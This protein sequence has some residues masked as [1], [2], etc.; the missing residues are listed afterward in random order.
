MKMLKTLSTLLFLQVNAT[1]LY[2]IAFGTNSFSGINASIPDGT[3]SGIQDVRIVASEIVELS[4][5]RI[6]LK[7][8]GN[9]NGDLYGY[10]RHQSGSATHISVLLNRPGRTA[11]NPN[12]YSDDGLDATFA[13]SAAADIHNYQSVSIPLPGTPL[14]GV[15]QPDGRFVDPTLVTSDSARSTLLS[16]F[17]GLSASGEWTLFLADVDPGGTNMLE[18]WGLEFIG[19]VLPTITWAAPSSIPYGTA[20]GTDQ[21][22]ATAPVPGTFS[23]SPAAGTVLHAGQGQALTVTF[24]PDDTNQY[25]TAT[26]SVAL[27]VL[28]QPL[29]ITSGSTNKTYGETMTF[30]GTEFTVTGLVNGDIVSSVTLT[31]PGTAASAPVGNHSIVPSAP[32]GINAANYNIN[33]VAGSLMVQP[34]TLAARA[35]DQS[36]PYGQTN[37]PLTIIYTGFVN[38]QNASIVTG[39]SAVTIADTNSPT[40]DYPITVS[41]QSAPNYTLS[42]MNGNLT[43]DPAPLSV[44]ANNV[45]CSYRGPNPILTA[46]ISGLMNGED[47]NVLDGALVLSTTA[48][49]ESAVGSYSIVPSGLSSTNYAIKFINGTLTVRPHELVI[50]AD[51]AGRIYGALNPAFTG[52]I[53][54]LQDGDNIT[55]TFTTSATTSSPVGAYAIVPTLSDPDGRLANYSITLTN[56]QL[57]IDPAPLSAML[58][59]P[60][61]FYGQTNPVFPI[62]YEGFVNGQDA[63][64]ITGPEGGT[65]TAQ[66]NSPIGTYPVTLAGQTAPNYSITPVN[67]ILTIVPAPLLVSADDARRALG[68]PNPIFTATI[69]GLMN[70]EDTNVLDGALVLSTTADEESAVG[71]YSIVPSGLSSTNYAIEFTNGTL[72]VTPYELVVTADSASRTYGALN[73]PFTGNIVGLQDGDNITASY[74]TPAT[75]SSPVGAYAIVPTLNDP[76]GKLTNYSVTLSHGQ[77]TVGPAP[78]LVSADDASRQFG[79]TNP[80]FTATISGLV[81]SDGINVL[82]GTLALTTFADVES[83]I[84]TY[85]IV[86]SGLTATNYAIQFTNGTLT[87]SKGACIAT[88]VSSVNPA[89]PNSP[90]MLRAS[91]AVSSAIS[92][93]P[94]GA[95]QFKID[96]VDYGIPVTLVEGIAALTT[97]SLQWGAHSISVE[98]QG[99]ANFLG[100]TNALPA[101]QIIDTPPVARPDTAY[102][103]LS[104]GTRMP[105]TYLLANDSDADGENVAFD[106][107]SLTSTAG[108]TVRLANGW[109]LYTPPAGFTNV[110]SFTYTIRDGLGVAGVGTVTISPLASLPLVRLTIAKSANQGS[111]LAISGPAW[112]AYAFQYTDSLR[113]A[114]WLSFGMGMADAS[115]Y[116]AFDDMM[117][118]TPSKRFYRAL[119]QQDMDT[120]LPFSFSLTCSPNPA[121]PGSL[122]TFTATLT[123]LAPGSGPPSGAVQFKV[124]GAN[125]GAPVSLT[126]GTASLSTATLPWGA[127]S[128]GAEYPGDGNFSSATNVLSP[129]LIIDT[130]P[131]AGSFVQPRSPTTGTKLPLSSLIA[132]ASD[133]DGEAITFD[134]FSPT[135]TEG[136]TVGLTNGWLYYTPPS[137]PIN[138]DSFTYEVRDSFGAIGVGTASIPTV[139]GTEPSPNLTILDLSAGNY[140]ILFSGVPWRTYN[141]QYAQSLPSASWQFLANASADSDGR[142]QYDDALPEGTPSRFY[143][144]VDQGNPPL[145]S[146]FRF[147]VWTNFIAQTNGRTMDMWSTRAYSAGF[148]DTP[149]IL[150]WNTNSLLYGR[151]GFT[152]ICQCSEF[153]DSP[154]QLPVTL[155][156]RRHGFM[157]GHG[158]SAV[159]LQTNGLAGKRLWFCTASNT[160][161]QMTIAAQFVRLGAL[162]NGPFYDYGLVIFTQDVPESITPISVISV[163]DFQTY[164]YNTPDIPYLT[165]GTEQNG[166]CATGGGLIPPF[167]YP[168]LKGGDSG[169]PDMLPSP[170]NKLIMFSG[171]GIS[172]F[173]PQVQADI[174]TLSLWL[175][176]NTNNYR[177]RWYDLSPWAP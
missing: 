41:G 6:R 130:P 109:I 13:D 93:K 126:A 40:G 69:T 118:P 128:V 53:V 94:T 161:V 59:D 43:V 58:P 57:T 125:Y 77:L 65:T 31:S 28:A 82:A 35:E 39:P 139:I 84:G 15:W 18:S 61:R 164:Y 88:I 54:G 37:P 120:M 143:R 64:V 156:T 83:S 55:A 46:T 137:G 132:A 144:A 141:I 42:F 97:S 86:P 89:L 134:S 49:E 167:I 169:S 174:D 73:P 47:T 5:V 147:A 27:D 101:P 168:L 98:Y 36:R 29:T 17:N 70:G 165:L 108:G 30:L 21:L 124:D 87:I 20:I 111:H 119:Y 75:T 177:I 14:S 78:L 50:T 159:G 149:P 9:F 26:G 34:A 11:L 19:K 33:F 52:N 107:V 56:G 38:G 74:T 51:N 155:L 76:D 22:N 113:P 152:A 48:D 81:N 166:H 44:A 96:G 158:Q 140:R 146:P 72:T 106:S 2:G 23:Y 3:T 150:A 63:S 71:T 153:E 91:L 24:V 157:R 160:P 90:V 102:R 1:S 142:F 175:G 138:A 116:L 85:D 162:S 62:I 172:G 100:S 25:A 60:S 7:V 45:S 8:A 173:S 105:I 123:E 32:V 79:Q 145:A 67:G 115:G 131:I 92:V 112:A 176:L 127:H 99:D 68:Q 135:S 103:A 154:G 117:Q 136:G 4:E 95:A 171:R 129:P 170:D 110:D 114:S 151:D 121:E 12:G 148:P 16:V 10:V 80:T 122:V 133:P 66:T 104:R 163:A